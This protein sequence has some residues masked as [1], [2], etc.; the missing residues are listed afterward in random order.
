MRC[1]CRK[2]TRYV[3]LGHF[4]LLLDIPVS[5]AHCLAWNRQDQENYCWFLQFLQRSLRCYFGT[6]ITTNRQTR[7]IVE[8]DESKFGKRKYNRGKWVDG[9][10][11]F[12]GIERD[13]SPSKCF[14]QTVSDRS[15]AT[16]IPIIKR[17]ILPGTT[18]LSD[19]WKAYNSLSA[20]G[21][22]HETVNHSVQLLFVSESGAHTNN[23]ESWWNALKKSLPKY[24]TNK[25]LYNSYFAEYCIRRKFLDNSGDK[26]LDQSAHAEP[27]SQATPTL[28]VS[29]TQAEGLL[30]QATAASA[31]VDSTPRLTRIKGQINFERRRW[32]NLCLPAGCHG[33]L[34]V[35]NS[36]SAS[37]AKNKHIR[38]CRKNYALGRKMIP[39]F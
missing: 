30:S 14:F 9:V 38:P 20:E 25:E 23:I 15:A 7:K 12:G 17:C 29:A 27:A 37:V 11:V 24:G 32:A 35:L 26:L 4:P 10:W 22:L 2:T 6:A 31:I 21:Y 13:S 28:P 8:I 39:S 33:N 3:I 5:A 34:P 19:C 36:L 16:L 18:I 1:N